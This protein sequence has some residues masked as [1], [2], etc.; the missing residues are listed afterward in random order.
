MLVLLSDNRQVPSGLVARTA[1]VL[2]INPEWLILGNPPLKRCRAFTDVSEQFASSHC[3]F[4]PTMMA[5]ATP[6]RLMI[7][8]TTVTAATTRALAEAIYTAHAH[9]APVLL[10]FDDTTLK[11][12][13][14]AL[15]KMIQVPWVTSLATTTAALYRDFTPS[16]SR[17]HATIRRAITYAA[18]V[19]VGLGEAVS[20]WSAANVSWVRSVFTTANAQNV[21]ITVHAHF[22]DAVDYFGAYGSGAQFGAE[23]GAA[24]YIDLLIFT[25]QI[26]EFVMTEHSVCINTTKN[27]ALG[28]LL[29][30]AIAA[31]YRTTKKRHGRVY[32]MNNQLLPFVV[33]QCQKVFEGD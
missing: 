31:A 13:R 7:P 5:P 6:G 9:H 15:L 33:E 18:R 19:G 12:C 8:R 32:K 4:N 23:L 29:L 10:L 11:E 30:N 25:E 21:P 2:D 16:Q 26:R 28:A 1:A 27:Q 17:R 14:E 20:R 22:G 3:L 24:S